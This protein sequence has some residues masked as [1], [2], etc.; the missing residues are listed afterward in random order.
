MVSSS[1]YTSAFVAS[2]ESV[3]RNET[4]ITVPKKRIKMMAYYL[5]F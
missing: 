5:H 1:H 4:A 3:T 2:N